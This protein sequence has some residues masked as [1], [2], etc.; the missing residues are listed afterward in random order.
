V[1]RDASA[2]RSMGRT[3]PNGVVLITTKSG[4]GRRARDSNTRAAR[5]RRRSTACRRAERDAV[6]RRGRAVRTHPSRF[7]AR[8]EHGLV[9]RHRPHGYGQEHNFAFTNG[10]DDQ[11]YRLSLGYLKQ[12]GIIRSS[13]LDRVSLSS[14]TGS[15]CPTV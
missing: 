12:E 8:P 11:S 7:V 5:P 10:G 9:R 14:T 2:A 15:S 3:R 1:L 4:K 6:R 13:D